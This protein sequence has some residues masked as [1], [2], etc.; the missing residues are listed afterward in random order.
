[1]NA[2]VKVTRDMN[3]VVTQAYNMCELMEKMPKESQIKINQIMKDITNKIEAE[4]NK[5]GKQESKDV[6]KTKPK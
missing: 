3:S 1:M 5:K 2:T 4:M 6:F